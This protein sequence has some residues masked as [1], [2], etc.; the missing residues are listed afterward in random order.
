M[1]FCSDGKS[2][3]THVLPYIKRDAFLQGRDLFWNQALMQNVKEE[4]FLWKTALENIVHRHYKKD[5]KENEELPHNEE[6]LIKVAIQ[7]LP[8]PQNTDDPTSAHE[9][10]FQHIFKNH[11]QYNSPLFYMPGDVEI[12]KEFGLH[13]FEP[14]YR[15]LISEV[16]SPYPAQYSRGDPITTSTDHKDF[17]TFLYANK[18]PLDVGASACIVQVKQCIIFPDRTSDV[19]LLPIAYVW[20]THLSQRPGSGGLVEARCIRMGAAQTQQLECQTVQTR[21]L[22]SLPPALANIVHI[23]E[24]RPDNDGENRTRFNG[25]DRDDIMEYLRS[26]VQYSERVQSTSNNHVE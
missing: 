3:L 25:L 20:I 18:K 7:A 10:L 17:P 4:P 1:I 15:L 8:L 19:F 23:Y 2:T 5:K 14:R 21:F 11:I 16:M 26:A 6:S 13:F 24:N 12:G 9:R 22:E